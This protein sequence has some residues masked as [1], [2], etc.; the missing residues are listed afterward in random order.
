MHRSFFPAGATGVIFHPQLIVRNG[1]TFEI[2]QGTLDRKSQ[3]CHRESVGKLVV[4]DFDSDGLVG[5]DI[6]NCDD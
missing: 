4:C 6:H 3:I 5:T 1:V 2:C